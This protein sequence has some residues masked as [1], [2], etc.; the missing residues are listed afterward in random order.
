MLP[1]HKKH[2]AQHATLKQPARVRD[3]SEI[4]TTITYLE[5]CL[6]FA[7][8]QKALSSALYNLYTYLSY[9][10]H[11]PDPAAASPFY[12]PAQRYELRMKP[13]LGI[14]GAGVPAYDVFEEWIRPWGPLGSE[15][16]ELKREM[17]DCIR[18]ME[19][20]IRE[21]KGHFKSFKDAGAEAAMCLGVETGW[22]KVCFPASPYGVAHATR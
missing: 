21:A 3:A 2:R 4:L 20:N 9:T 1:V 6:S 22:G 13:F 16:D 17:A 18:E 12:T 14:T 11:I 5:S 15:N 7:Q 8:G 19:E 10:H